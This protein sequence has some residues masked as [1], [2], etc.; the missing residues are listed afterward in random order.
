MILRIRNASCDKD[1]IDNRILY[2]FDMILYEKC[3]FSLGNFHIYLFCLYNL[4]LYLYLIRAIYDDGEKK[5]W[6]SR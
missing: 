3:E 5:A 4:Q 2:E 6:V 1:M